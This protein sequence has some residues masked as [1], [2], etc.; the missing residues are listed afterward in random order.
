MNY[1][2]RTTNSE[3][4]LIEVNENLSLIAETK[5]LLIEYGNYMYQELGLIAGKENFFKDLENFPG[6]QYKQPW[7]TFV[8]AKTGE[9][10]VGCI[11]IRKFNNDSCEMKRMYIAKA[12]R[13]KGI[14]RILCN[15]VINWC[16]QSMYKRILLDTNIEMKEAVI[17]Y[18]KCGFKEIEPYCINENK[19]PLFMEYTF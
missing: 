7:G 5:K 18:R 15:F 12:Y 13:G 19:D 16:R 10:A 1:E 6:D 8:I 14:G 9:V 4:R 17:L 3:L 2:L 11:G